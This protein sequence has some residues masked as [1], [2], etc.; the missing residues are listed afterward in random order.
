M[1]RVP[2]GNFIRFV[3]CI[4]LLCVTLLFSSV[5]YPQYV[6]TPRQNVAINGQINGFWEYLP[7]GYSANPT[8]TYPLLV[9]LHGWGEIGTG[10]LPSMTSLL[11]HGVPRV[12]E[13]GI[14]PQSVTFNGQSYSFI[15]LSPQYLSLGV[16]VADLDQFLEYA[17]AHYRV[18]RNRVYLTGFSNGG[19][20]CY[21][22][23]GNNANYAQKIA[24]IV[25]LAPCIGPSFGQAQ[26]IAQ[27]NVAVWGIHGSQDVNGPCNVSFTPAWSNMINTANNNT[28]PSPAAVYSLIPTF[29]GAD[30][31]DIFW[32]TFESG[33]SAPPTNKNM[34]D[35]MIQ[36]SRNSGTPPPP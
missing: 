8:K 15:V 25:P 20:L 26:T 11:I 6:E 22:Y 23:A 34:Y 35:W 31:H 14:F 3:G 12:I 36:Y 2:C 32:G 19:S 21:S 7:S 16:S 30:T 10:N 28:P 24:G 29:P 5:A 18:D 17:F 13:W 9:F 27:N 33:F 4:S 1:E